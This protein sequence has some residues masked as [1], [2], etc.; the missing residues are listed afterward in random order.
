MRE[1]YNSKK[2]SFEVFLEDR[3]IPDP[4]ELLGRSLKYLKNKGQKVILL[5]FDNSKNPIVNIDEETYIFDKIFGHW[6]G[7]KF[8]KTSIDDFTQEPLSRKSKIEKYYM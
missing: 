8:T 4:D 2:N 7:A 6:Q 3:I 1:P 5:G